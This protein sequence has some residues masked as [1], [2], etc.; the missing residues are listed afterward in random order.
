MAAEIPTEE[1]I[2]GRWGLREPQFFYDC[3]GERVIVR[4]MNGD[5]LHGYITGLDQY[6]IG[7]EVDGSP[8]PYWI[9]KHA[10]AYIVRPA[11]L[12]SE[13]QHV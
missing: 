11:P 6:A 12:E 1:K 4:L 9:N 3:D 8:H 10:I 2:P 5:E 13:E 7:V